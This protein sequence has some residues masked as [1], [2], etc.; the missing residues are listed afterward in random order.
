MK[1]YDLKQIKNR[2]GAKKLEDVPEEVKY[3]L[4]HGEISA[5]NLMKSLVIDNNLLLKNVLTDLGLENYI[6]S[7]TEAINNLDKK[8][9]IKCIKIIGKTLSKEMAENQDTEAIKLLSKHDSDTVR[10]WAAYIIGSN[11]EIDILNKL[12]AIKPFASD[13][14]WGVRE[15]AWMAVRNSIINNLK[16][17]IPY[18]SKWS[19]DSDPNIRRFT[20]ESTRPR[21]VWCKHSKELKENPEIGLPIIDPL[22]SDKKKYVQDSVGNWLN[23]ASKS[24][25][26]WVIELCKKWNKV[27]PTKETK[28]ITNR[29][30]RTLNK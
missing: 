19:K 13:D 1:K 4:N 17:S 5:M 29:G 28:R 12:T 2:K 30:L 14:A 18:L 6:K 24:K 16:D 23:D 9:H 20:S 11:E 15:C 26:T 27:S 10:S 25:G 8:T 7:P 22:K 21:G 3:L